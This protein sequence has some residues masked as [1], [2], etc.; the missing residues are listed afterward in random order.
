MTTAKNEFPM[1]LKPK[2]AEAPNELAVS[3]ATA[4]ARYEIESAIIISKKMP[5][6]E[7][8]A[9]QKLMAA[10]KRPAF[11]E[12][13]L[14][15]FPRG[16]TTIS[17]ASVNL[18]REAAR[19]WGNIRYGIEILR[20]D[21][22]SRMILGWAW[23][24]ETNVKVTAGDD[25]KKL[26]QRKTG[27]GKFR[28]TEWVTPDE[29]DLRELTFRRG[30]ILIRNC[31]LQLMPKDFIEDA[32][33]AV[34]ETM[35][36]AAG[37]DPDEQ[38]KKT[39]LA[40]SEFGINPEMLEKYLGHPLA[41]CIPSEIANLKKIYASIRDGN[42]TWAE[43]VQAEEKAKLQ[44][45]V[46]SLRRDKPLTPPPPNPQPATP[47]SEL[48]PALTPE[49]IQEKNALIQKVVE[50]NITW[51]ELPESGRVIMKETFGQHFN[52]TR[53][54]FRQLTIPDVEQALAYYQ[55]V[56]ETKVKK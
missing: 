5:R 56:A 8:A 12:D 17:G 19:V 1:E 48:F 37:K 21:E 26:V 24:L 35:R 6:N 40:F 43:Y 18:A 32:M 31:I 47:G 15:S 10:A 33:T 3:N 38:K 51:D 7:D 45:G 42:S 11:A 34:E 50:T 28:K 54:A 27:E 44:P 46:V 30:A 53:D 16:G 25:F 41:Q 39:I 20:D 55:K 52:G 14:Y 13:A 2:Q 49:E 23:D 29:R 36:T 9:Y 4:Q 22:T